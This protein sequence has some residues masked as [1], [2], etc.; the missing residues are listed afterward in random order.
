MTTI[1][2]K[3]WM[4]QVSDEKTIDQLLIPGTHDTMTGPCDLKYYKTQNLSLAEQLEVGVRF[5]DLRIRRSLMAAHR[6]WLSDASVTDI[7][8]CIKQ[9]LQENSTEV[10]ILRVQNANEKKDDF[11]EYGE[12]I[13]EALAPYFDFFYLPNEEKAWP[14]LGQCRGKAIV[15]ECAPPELKVNYRQGKQWAFNWH[16]ND[17]VV[18]QDLW[19]GPSVTDKL[20]AIEKNLADSLKADGKLYLNH[21]S[22]TNGEIGN[23]D[24]Y[25]EKINPAVQEKFA[26]LK[27]SEY[28]GV[29]IYDFV[30]DKLSKVV[31]K[32]NFL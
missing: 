22:A 17:A 14:K 10:M 23:P 24:G 13:K 7:F 1:N 19:D 20:S 6:E 5:L 28:R 4:S 8:G 32:V 30:D 3:N 25:A 31:I 26:E 16:G 9:F 2:L 18:I 29:Q 21:I 15:F 27:S 11:P 12:A